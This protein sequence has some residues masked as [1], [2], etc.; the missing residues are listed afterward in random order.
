MVLKVAGEYLEWEVNQKQK[1][2]VW[3]RHGCFVSDG[4]IKVLLL[5]VFQL[6]EHGFRFI[7]DR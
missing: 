2:F 7:G 3:M 1:V 4:R 6:K 5:E